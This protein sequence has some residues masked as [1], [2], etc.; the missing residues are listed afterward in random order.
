MLKE[1]AQIQPGV[2]GQTRTMKWPSDAREISFFPA[3]VQL[4]LYSF[5]LSKGLDLQVMA[6][7]QPVLY[8]EKQQRLL[9]G[10]AQGWI[11][12]AYAN[13]VPKWC[14]YTGDTLYA[15]PPAYPTTL[16]D[17]V[18]LVEDYVSALVVQWAYPSASCVAL[19]GTALR[20][21]ELIMR[22]VGKTVLGMFDGDAAGVKG[23]KAA[24]LRLTGLG[25]TYCTVIVPDGL[26]PK[27]L[28]KLVITQLIQETINGQINS[29][30]N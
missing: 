20:S 22:L 1:H 11:G 3:H 12:R 18:I 4:G 10:T 15:C 13:Q 29:I 2:V 23:D 25:I 5:M 28:D 9:F 21:R 7:G 26:D 8:S 27:D 16:K 6:P 14:N 19:L 24:R 30:K 17:I